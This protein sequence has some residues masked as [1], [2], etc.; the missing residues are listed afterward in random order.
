[1]LEGV[2]EEFPRVEHLWVD[3]GREDWYH[4]AGL[5][6]F[7]YEYEEHLA[8]RREVRLP[9]DRVEKRQNSIE[10]ILPQ[11]PTD[12]Y[13]TSRFDDE[14]RA[15]LTHDLGNLCLTYDNSSYGNKP[16]PAKRGG[17]E[18]NRPCYWTSVLYQEQELAKLDEWNPEELLKR[19]R[20]MVDWAL[21]RWHVEE[22]A[23]K[24]PD[25]D[26][27]EEAMMLEEEDNLDPLVVSS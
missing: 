24:A 12:E 13:W 11:T 26:D 16:F 17:P 15:R 4:W 9:W 20:A 22:I 18:T 21:R 27:E 6:Y 3:Q 14:Q 10:H 8:G 19:R 1:M 5:K 25:L 23:H 2:A 7:L